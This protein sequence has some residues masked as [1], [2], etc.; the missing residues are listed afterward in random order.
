MILYLGTSSLVK[1]YVDEAHSDAVR[2]WARDAEI[3]A[4]CR[5][6]YTET[7]SALEKRLKHKDLTVK[8]YEQF[9]RKL[10]RDWHHFAVLD[11]DDIEAGRLVKKHGLTRLDAIH[12]SSAKM[13]KKGDSRL[14]LSFSSF[15]Q[16]LCEA[17]AAEGLRVLTV[18]LPAIPEV[19][20]PFDQV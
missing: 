5:V 16:R 18:C 19:T 11:F 14:S 7:I 4:T 10:E 13:L 8:D 12:L 1:L 17:A 9:V 3:L 2:Q 15:N 6:A 20:T